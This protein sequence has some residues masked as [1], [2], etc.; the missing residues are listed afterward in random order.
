MYW[1]QAVYIA[2]LIQRGELWRAEQ[3]LHC[4]LRR[5]LLAFIEWHTLASKGADYKLSIRGRFLEEWADSRITSALNRELITGGRVSLQAELSKL[6][7]M[8][9]MIVDETAQLLG[10]ASPFQQVKELD[11]WLSDLKQSD[12]SKHLYSLIQLQL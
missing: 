5:I 9:Q 12:C 4:E 1:L 10:F 8:C 7:E 6:C 2:Q 3:E 11:L